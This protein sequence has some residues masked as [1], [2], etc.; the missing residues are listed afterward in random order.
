VSRSN[1]GSKYEVFRSPERCTLGGWVAGSLGGWLAGV[2]NHF[3][4]FV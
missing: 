2:E 1:L 4:V 3:S